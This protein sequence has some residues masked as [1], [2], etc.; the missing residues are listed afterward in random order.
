MRKMPL[1]K[2]IILK[3]NAVSRY[4]THTNIP[5]KI[6]KSNSDVC[7]EPFTQTFNDR[8][9]NS[10]FPDEL[11]CANVTSL[12]KNGPTNTRTNFRPIDLLAILKRI[13]IE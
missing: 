8:V 1:L 12:P 3:K 6:L 9:G 2:L 13:R 7:V 11:K 10:T 5:P 4:G